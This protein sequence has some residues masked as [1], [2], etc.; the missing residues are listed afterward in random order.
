MIITPLILL[1][2]SDL[3]NIYY[4]PP[5]IIVSHTSEIICKCYTKKLGGTM[6]T[7]SPPTSEVSCSNP[8]PYVI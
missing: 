5:N 6:V 8:V 1:L 3:K 2:N 4:Y 7:H